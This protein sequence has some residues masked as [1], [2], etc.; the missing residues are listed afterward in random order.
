MKVLYF[1]CFSGI[2]GDM[3]LGALL[4]IGVDE[5]LFREELEKLNLEGYELV[6]S[7]KSKNGIFGTDVKVILTGEKAPTHEHIH[8]SEHRHEHGHGQHQHSHGH[9]EHQHGHGERNLR[10]IEKLIDESGI[11]PA[12][13]EFSKTVFREIAGAEARVHNKDISEVHFHEVGA[14]DSIVDIVGVAICLDMLGVEKVVSSVLHDGH[15]FIKC[16]HGTIPVPVPAVMEMLAGSNIP[17]VRTDISTELITPTGMGI[18]KCIS[19]GF[20]SMPI[21]AVK[22]IGYGM[23]KRDTGGFNA[24]RVVIGEVAGS[25]ET[26]DEIV[27]LET[28]IDNMNPEILG[29]TM[30]KLFNHGALDVFYTPVFMKKNRPAV[31]LSV[32]STVGK[33][34]GLVQVMLEETATLGIRRTLATRYCMDR[35][36]VT[37]DTGWGAVRVKVASM[38][39]VVKASP[40]YEDCADI[41]R[42]TGVPLQKVMDKAREVYARD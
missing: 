4:D 25:V 40:E 26:S 2:S 7:K 35:K 32:L 41:A 3:T 13:K 5:K 12:A 33:E 9:D 17:L 42:R 18:I 8:D 16:Q 29:Y 1:D 21:M 31:M 19:S 15:G 20:G 10:D 27:V 38:G 23:G 22:K 37:V 34:R 11:K 24:L 28:N 6:V 30:E 39:D 36:H 14:V